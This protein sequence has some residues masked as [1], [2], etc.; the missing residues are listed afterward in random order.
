M[1]RT[2]FAFLKL[3]LVWL[4]A[5]ALRVE[6]LLAASRP[7]HVSPLAEGCGHISVEVQP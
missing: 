1:R 3:L 7:S 5:L 6:L 2:D 4:L